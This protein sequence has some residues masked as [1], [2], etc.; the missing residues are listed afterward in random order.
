MIEQGF[1]PVERKWGKLRLRPDG[2]VTD[3]HVNDE[4]GFVRFTVGDKEVIYDSAEAVL[5]GDGNF[6]DGVAR[7][8]LAY[9][10]KEA[11]TFDFG[12]KGRI[13]EEEIAIAKATGRLVEEYKEHD[14]KVNINHG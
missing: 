13:F 7:I 8:G 3:I 14:W 1:I 11:P 12:H 9:F 4:F 6:D 10:E 5:L 2:Q